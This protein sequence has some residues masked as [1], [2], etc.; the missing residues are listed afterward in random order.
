MMHVKAINHPKL[1]ITV[2]LFLIQSVAESLHKN[3]IGYCKP[4]IR[5]KWDRPKQCVIIYSTYD[6][7]F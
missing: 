1:C 3:Y 2:I 5:T 6:W 7:L 4:R